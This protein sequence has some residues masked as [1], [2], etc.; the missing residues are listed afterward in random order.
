MSAI[1]KFKNRKKSTPT[2]HPDGGTFNLF[3]FDIS[4]ALGY[5]DL[6]ESW[7]ELK[8][9][10]TQQYRELVQ[11]A[12]DNLV[13]GI[14]NFVDVDTDEALEGSDENICALLGEISERMV[15][16][17]VDGETKQVPANE[18]GFVWAIIESGKLLAK[19]EGEQKNC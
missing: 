14:S 13:E 4:K 16:I 10:E 1:R 5:Q 7:A 6:Q 17:V 12:K 3:P 19:R 18:P 8:T 9:K 11:F 15:D 2:D